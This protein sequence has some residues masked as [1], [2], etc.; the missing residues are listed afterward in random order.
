MNR[1]RDGRPVRPARLPARSPRVPP[2][3]RAFTQSDP[4]LPMTHLP[5]SPPPADAASRRSRG[6]FTLIELLVV[7]AIIAILVSLLLPAVQQ[8]REAA[9][10]SQC[11]NNL[12]QLGLAMHN[13]HS[14]YKVLPMAWGGTRHNPPYPV[15]NPHGGDDNWFRLSVFVPLTPFLDNGA[16]WDSISSQ[17]TMPDRDGNMLTWLPMGPGP[18]ESHYLPW[19]TQLPVLLCPSD[20]APVRNCADRNYGLNWGDNGFPNSS[21]SA[22]PRNPFATPGRDGVTPRGMGDRHNNLSFASVQDG[23]TNTILLGEIGRF[24]GG[25]QFFGDLAINMGSAIYQNP[26]VECREAVESVQ[27]PGVYAVGVDLSL[28]SDRK[29]GDRWADGSVQN[30][31]FNTIFPPNG[32]NCN[33]DDRDDSFGGIFS[34]ASQHSGIVQV[35]LCDGSVQSISETID[36]GDLTQPM[37]TDRNQVRQ[38][39]IYGT[40]GALGS[41]A[42]GEIIDGAF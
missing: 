41:R 11:Q 1:S 26:Q 12:K 18:F 16:L 13:Y 4:V 8:A 7:I 10:R 20:S 28:F 3:F 37:P 35:L 33:E 38:N 21:A 19:R 29:R 30:G 17:S 32:P 36:T 5:Q 22:W 34:A 40:W 27:E 14:T 6:G 39:S 15:G 2:V 23:L 24:N 31:G 25:R 9:R 42:G